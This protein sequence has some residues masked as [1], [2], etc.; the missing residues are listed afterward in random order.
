MYD[1][2]AIL[3]TTVAVFFSR[4]TETGFCRVKTKYY[5]VAFGVTTHT[6]R[7]DKR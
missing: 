3:C 7:G 2:Q 5:A 6:G 4:F 1:R